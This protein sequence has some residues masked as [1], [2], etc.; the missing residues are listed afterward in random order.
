MSN[1]A[2]RTSYSANW[3]HRLLLVSFKSVNQFVAYDN[4]DNDDNFLWYDSE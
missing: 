1:D 4:N 3:S 2:G